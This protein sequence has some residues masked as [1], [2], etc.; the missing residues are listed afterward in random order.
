MVLSEIPHNIYDAWDN[1]QKGNELEE[2]WNDDFRKYENDYPDEA[3]EL[4]RRISSDLPEEWLEKSQE[5][6]KF[7]NEKKRQL[8]QEKLHRI[9]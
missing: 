8:P 6:I 1:T 4:I 7:C 2:K 5:Y 9:R 3:K